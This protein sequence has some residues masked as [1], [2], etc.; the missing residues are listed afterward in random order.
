MISELANLVAKVTGYQGE[1]QF[2]ASKPDGAP[3]KLMN[4]KL[5]NNLGWMPEVDLASG[6]DR[7]YH[8]FIKHTPNQC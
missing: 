1:I 7:T 2:D 6:I 3:K 4:S 5:L 8:D